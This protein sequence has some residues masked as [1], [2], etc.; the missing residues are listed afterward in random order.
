MI[1]FYLPKEIN[2]VI[3]KIL[4]SSHFFF[5]IVF[6]E[7]SPKILIIRAP[8][9]PLFHHRWISLEIMIS[10]LR[11]SLVIPRRGSINHYHF[12]IILS[13]V[14]TRLSS[15]ISNEEEEG[16]SLMVTLILVLRLDFLA[17]QL[18]S[19]MTTL[20]CISSSLVAS[21]SLNW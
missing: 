14:L 13:M 18:V 10:I 3:L 2:L 7:R 1:N 17:N 6:L 12:S 15:F 19:T 8:M 11:I 16:C 4:F 20:I 21:L 5:S 9:F